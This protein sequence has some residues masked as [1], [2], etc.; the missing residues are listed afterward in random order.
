MISFA[1]TAY[2]EMTPMRLNGTR[3]MACIKAAL[4]HPAIDEIVVVDD[5]SENFDQLTALVGGLPKVKPFANPTNQGVFGNKL[6]AIARSS[7]DWV[8]N[9]DSD[10]LM[11]TAY[12]DLVLTVIRDKKTWYCPSFARPKFDYRQHIGQHTLKDIGGTIEA[13][14]I[15]C[16]LMNT[17][18]QTVHRESF[19]ELFQQYRQQR[20]DLMFP[21]WLGLQQSQRTTLH[22]RL[23]FD[24][25]DSLLF[26]STWLQNGGTLQVV[27]GLEYDHHYS[28]GND[29]NYVRAPQEKHSLNS[30]IT[31]DLIKAS[32]KEKHG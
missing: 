15:I 25:C 22:Y 16:C 14:G 1:V 26:N 4:A 31:A 9:C 32:R 27:A 23:A 17:G 2:K 10:N 6:E 20:A 30:L 21:N 18:N 19:M 29:S 12:I 3:I 11:D 24:A 13:G 28:A 8:I 7:G 5:A